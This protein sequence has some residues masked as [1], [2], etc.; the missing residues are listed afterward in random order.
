MTIR[1][2]NVWHGANRFSWLAGPY[3]H[4]HMVYGNVDS[5]LVW[6]NDND[7]THQLWQGRLDA[8]TTQ[9]TPTGCFKFSA[10]AS[11]GWTLEYCWL[12]NEPSI[13]ECLLRI[14]T[15][16]TWCHYL[17]MCGIDHIMVFLNVIRCFCFTVHA[18]IGWVYN[19]IVVINF[20]RL[21]MTISH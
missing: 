8:D 10:P 15:C 4:K 2:I 20:Q 6:Y 1:Y 5:S 21:C 11:S 13:T 14:V 3:W 18:M 9:S 17:F 16:K 7:C 12:W 19:T